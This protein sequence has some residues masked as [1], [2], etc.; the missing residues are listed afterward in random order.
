M[1]VNSR[2]CPVLL[3]CRVL[4]LFIPLHLMLEYY[5]LSSL[6]LFIHEAPQ[7]PPDSTYV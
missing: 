5:Q 4:C 2:P 3:L 1:T 6:S 7:L